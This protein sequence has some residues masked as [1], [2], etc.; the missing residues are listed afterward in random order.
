MRK[1]LCAALGSIVLVSALG[2]TAC[3]RETADRCRYTIA[4]EYA[5]EAETLTAT[6]TCDVV[7]T[8]SVAL[9]ALKFQ[10]WANAFR[11]GAKTPPVSDLFRRAGK[12]RM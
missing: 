6:M 1:I 10:L 11:K 5:E 2:L 12:P 9:P 3:H 4:A 7:N 8:S